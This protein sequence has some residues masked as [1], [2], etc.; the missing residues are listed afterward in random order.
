MQH[1]AIY[2][3]VSSRKQNTKSQEPDLRQWSEAYADGREIWYHDT[4]SGRTM[5]R[6]GWKRLEREINS[7]RV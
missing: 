6:P 5:D 4:W 7:G 1:I 2:T 3:R